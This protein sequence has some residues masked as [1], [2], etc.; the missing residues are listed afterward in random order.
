MTF[1]IKI[2]LEH[3]VEKS[4]A[5]DDTAAKYGSGLLEIF[6]TPALL[7][8]MEDAAYHAVLPYLPE[9]YTTVGTEVNIKHVKAVPIG[10]TVRGKA[11]LR[12]VEGNKLLFDVTAFDNENNII[13]EGTHTRYII[14]IKRFLKQFQS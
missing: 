12:Q 7:T 10:G 6:S 14:E 8:L 3:V 5:F 4:V 9:A 13:G 1:D 2:G 11:I